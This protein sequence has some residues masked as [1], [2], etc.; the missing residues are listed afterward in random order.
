[1]YGTLEILEPDGDQY[2]FELTQELVTIGRAQECEVTLADQQTSRQHTQVRCSADGCAVVDLGSTNGT[3]VQGQRL[4]ANQPVPLT[5]KMVFVL[6]RTR[7]RYLAPSKQPRPAAPPPPPVARKE[8]PEQETAADRPPPIVPVE[9]EPPKPKPAAPPPPPPPPPP[10]QPR[11]AGP[12]APPS[13]V[14]LP[15][16][17]SS[18]LANLPAIYGQGDFIGRFLLIFEH[19]LLPVDR[20][21]DHLAL[22]FDPRHTP[23]EL[24]PWLAS[25][26]DL[27]LDETWPEER[28][29]ELIQSAVQLYQWRGTNRGLKEYLR[30][31]TG[32]EPE[33]YE[34]ISRM[35]L[36]KEP[37]TRGRLAAQSFVVTL[38]VP[39]PD[40]VD[41]A[42]VTTIVEA[43]KPAHTAYQLRVEKAQ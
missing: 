21:I 30:I 2:N 5:D 16:E 3:T 24:L 17:V 33:I 1:M 27:V 9:K 42:K 32:V 14:S 13:P 38:R 4:P 11:P 20:Q 25:W 40:D 15:P 22:L 7:I 6:G 18:Y 35:D 23:A 28:R 19:L 37:D 39:D 31:Y 41:R 43:E 10:A 34:P 36:S 12:A 26:V 29:R 8:Q